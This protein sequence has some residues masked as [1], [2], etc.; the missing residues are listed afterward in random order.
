MRYDKAL[1]KKTDDVKLW[2]LASA[3]NLLINELPRALEISLEGIRRFPEKAVLYVHAGDTLRELKR[4]DEAFSY[5]RQSLV[6][7]KTFL[8]ALFS[9]AFCYEELENFAEAHKVWIEITQE[10]D[11]CGLTIEREFPAERAE[12]CLKKLH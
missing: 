4:Y 11:R 12:K 3:V 7:D 8:D 5:W 1:A 10:L 2:V 9:M 6:L